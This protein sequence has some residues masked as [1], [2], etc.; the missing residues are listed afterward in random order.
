MAS[1]TS[2]YFASTASPMMWTT[3]DDFG[4]Y[5]PPELKEPE[6]IKIEFCQWCSAEYY[7]STW[8]EGCCASCGGPKHWEPDYRE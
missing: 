1:S 5:S 6:P 4:D 7:P 8:R 2:V 3:S